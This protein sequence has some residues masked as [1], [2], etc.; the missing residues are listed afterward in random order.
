M[1]GIAKLRSAFV[2]CIMMSCLLAGCG[3]EEIPRE[4]YRQAEQDAASGSTQSREMSK[5]ELLGYY[6]AEAMYRYEKSRPSGDGEEAVLPAL[7]TLGEE[8][9][10]V[11]YWLYPENEM[12]EEQ[13]LKIAGLK[14]GTIPEEA[15]I[16]KED[17]IT[18]EDI[19]RITEELMKS[20]HIADTRFREVYPLYWSASA[21]GVMPKKEDLW[22]ARVSCESGYD[23]DVIMDA[24]DGVLKEWKRKPKGWYDPEVPA[25]EYQ[26]KEAAF[27][28]DEEYIQA[29]KKYCEQCEIVDIT[30]YQLYP[31]IIKGTPEASESKMVQAFTQT[32]GCHRI[33]IDTSDLSVAGLVLA[34]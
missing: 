3:K 6:R 10:Q 8:G 30:D 34:R 32:G 4:I 22:E 31:D 18:Y 12:T 15:Y 25:G 29:A 33:L 26:A 19:S 5:K 23:Y 2:T 21:S 7:L 9:S 11:S 17:Q 28:T 16:P 13:L 24:N 14:F 20:F 27:F 1:G